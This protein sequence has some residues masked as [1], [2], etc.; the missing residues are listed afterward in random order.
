MSNHLESTSSR[1][2]RL[3]SAESRTRQV[4][5]RDE[6]E[7]GALTSEATRTAEWDQ[8]LRAKTGATA[9]TSLH[10]LRSAQVSETYL[11]CQAEPV[12]TIRLHL[13][14]LLLE[15]LDPRDSRIFRVPGESLRDAR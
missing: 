5:R 4:N 13:G 12:I 11:S 10:I 7:Q 1:T 8:T 3:P 9:Q 15:V 2:L 14:Q 6:H